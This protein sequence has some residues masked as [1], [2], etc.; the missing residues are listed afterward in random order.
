VADPVSTDLFTDNGDAFS[1][2]DVPSGDVARRAGVG[3][4]SAFRGLLA[5]VALQ[6]LAFAPLSIANAA[7]GSPVDTDLVVLGSGGLAVLA[8]TPLASRQPLV[9]RVLILPAVI[10]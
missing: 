4:F 2:S 5:V 3:E 1:V 9:D 6:T 8:G 10:T 7:L